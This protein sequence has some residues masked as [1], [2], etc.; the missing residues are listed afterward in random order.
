MS[1][2]ADT[3]LVGP[4]GGLRLLRVIDAGAS[5]SVHLAEVV[6]SPGRRVAAKRF[7]TAAL[8]GPGAGQ[9]A[10][11]R[12]VGVAQREFSALAALE[13]AHVLRTLPPPLGLFMEDREGSPFHNDIFL[14]TELAEGGSAKARM[15]AAGA[16]GGGVDGGAVAAPTDAPEAQTEKPPTEPLSARLVAWT[17]RDLVHALAY[18]HLRPGG[19]ARQHGDVKPG[20]VLYSADGRALLAD[21]SSSRLAVRI[22]SDSSSCSPLTGATPAFAAPETLL[23][24]DAASPAGDVWSLGATLLCLLTGHELAEAADVRRSLQSAAE[25][26]WT[27]ERHVARTLELPL[28]GGKRKALPHAGLSD[29]ERARWEAAPEGLRAF[30][31]R[32]L[33]VDA[34]ARPTAA[35]LCSDDFIATVEAVYSPREATPA[36]VGAAAAELEGRDITP[37]R[38]VAL[39]RE[40]PDDPDVVLAAAR[41]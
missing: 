32:C 10:F 4:G 17:A 39:M 29:A 20:N 35:E 25:P 15:E 27:L 11:A 18:L 38:A 36:P 13:H 5:A 23:D 7:A 6:A 30:V 41:G 33:V 21:F 37:A 26:L 24:T 1:A 40:Y 19:D 9:L 22:A 34:D 31:K 8:C 14:V 3:N 28:M 12:V 16:A 2:S